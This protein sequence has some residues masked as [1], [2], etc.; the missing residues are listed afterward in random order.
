MHRD[1]KTWCVECL[2]CQQ[3]KVSRHVKNEPSQFVAPDGRF[4]HVHMDIV[5]PLKTCESYS[6]LLTIV[7]RFSRWVEAIPLKDITADTVLRAFQTEWV[8]RYGAPRF[9][10]TDQGSQ[11]E[12]QLFNAYLSFI[13]CQRKRTVAYHP[14]ANGMIERW[15]RSLKAALMCHNNPN[16]VK[17]LPTVMLGLRTAVR[18]DTGA[19]PAEFIF[20]TTLRIPGEFFI[21]DD[22]LPDPQIFIEDYREYMRELRPVPVAHRHKL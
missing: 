6:Y 15:H 22:F 14:A 18:S 13:G 8:A 21:P 20:G 2:D 9:L 3:S 7:D 4:R 11:F 19:S 5:G 17:Q 12:S 1:I 16:W 10:T